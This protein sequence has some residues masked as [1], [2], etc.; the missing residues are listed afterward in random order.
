[1]DQQVKKTQSGIPEEAYKFWPRE[2]DEAPLDVDLL[3]LYP[4]LATGRV[5]KAASRLI[6][7]SFG[8]PVKTGQGMRLGSLASW[9]DVGAIV[10]LTRPDI[11]RNKDGWLNIEGHLSNGYLVELSWLDVVRFMWRQS[12]PVALDG[13][14]GLKLSPPAYD[15]VLGPLMSIIRG[16][17]KPKPGE[18]E[19]LD[20]AASEWALYTLSARIIESVRRGV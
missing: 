11:H 3:K 12:M 9:N 2:F 15:R 13:A 1:M 7:Y 20:K 18:R 16:W 19:Q 14:D 4:G 6:V 8:S 17:V 5:G 10:F